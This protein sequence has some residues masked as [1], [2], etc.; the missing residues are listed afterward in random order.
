MKKLLVAVLLVAFAAAPALAADV[1]TYPSEKFKKGPVVFDH[2]AHGDALG[3]EA[4]HEGTPA[5]IEIT[6]ESAHK[7][8]CKDCHKEKGVPSKCGDCH[9]K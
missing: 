3:C 1:Y 8:A 6:K 2:K 9:K 7:E 5:K 4:C